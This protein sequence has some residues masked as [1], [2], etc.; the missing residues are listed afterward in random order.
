MANTYCMIGENRNQ[1]ACDPNTGSVAIV[2]RGDDRS[3]DG[4]GNTLYIRYS[5]DDGNSWSPKG[6]N[7]AT[8]DQPRYPNIFLPNAGETVPQTALLWPQVVSFGDGS[9][10]FGE[11]NA[12]KS[13]L[14]NQSPAYATVPGPPDWGIPWSIMMDRSTGDLYSAAEAI[15]PSNGL[16]YEE[17]Y[18]L[19]STDGGENW[20]AASLENPF[21][22]SGI[23]PNGYAALSHRLSI[24]PNGSTMVA[25]WVQLSETEPGRANL[26]DEL[27]AIAWRI[28]T[29]GGESWGEVQTVRLSELQDRPAPFETKI[30][31][32][33]DLDVVL[34]ADNIPHFLTVCSADLNPFNPFDEA[35]P[36]S[37]INLRHVDSTFVTEIFRDTR[38][39]WHILP[40]GPVYRVRTDRLAF[41]SQSESDEAA[42]F[43]NEV[44]WARNGDGT[45]LWA[46]WITPMLTWTV[47]DVAGT[48][49]LFEDTIT[50]IYANGRHIA[51]NLK[52]PWTY[53]WD[54]AE[55]D[56]NTAEMDSM[57]RL[58]ALTDVGAK[59]TKMAAYAGEQD[60]LHILFV[61]WGIG[62][63]TDD[64]PLLA[65]QYVWYLTGANVPVSL[66]DARDDRGTVA[67]FSLEANSPNPFTG[68]T[69]IRY[70]LP[71]GMYMRLAVHDALGREVARLVDGQQSAG[72]HSVRFN[73]GDLPAGIYFC[74][75]DNGK[76]STSRKLM[77]I[78]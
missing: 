53:S 70:S 7:V 67:Q 40:A 47:A 15:D 8:T 26:I 18:L 30:A 2:F 77:L 58:T 66:V 25:S 59:Y 3:P 21:F 55:P 75:M 54:F 57:M 5:T 10:G 51:S 44:A 28:S 24:S 43:R 35:L 17:Y 9:E 27:H 64:D 31:Q 45:K 62:E 37:S 13:G 73:A 6:G 76:T 60:Q 38:G 34:D 50:Q 42:V 56:H 20:N 41:T 71:H 39:T 78:R 65:N 46:K 68:G 1:I 4:D 29:N 22:K 36:D 72:R 11:I 63:R 48:P 61:E 74:K 14:M 16:S 19:K 52:R 49:T 23:V 32:S 12:M 69:A 33:W